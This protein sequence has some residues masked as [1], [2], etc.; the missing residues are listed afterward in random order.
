MRGSIKLDARKWNAAMKELAGLAK[1]KPVVDVMKR[2]AGAVVRRVVNVTPPAQGKADASAKKAGEGTIFTDLSRVM[3][4]V[5]QTK[6]AKLLDPVEVYKQTHNP[7]T[8]RV[9]GRYRKQRPVPAQAFNALKRQL[10]GKVGH[11][12]AGFNAAAQKLGVRL[13]A[14][15]TRHGLRFGTIGIF[16]KATGVRITFSN[17]VKFVDNVSDLGR[18]L[19]WALNTEAKS[20]IERQLPNAVRNVGKSA[21]FKT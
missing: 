21:G 18:R 20:I 16:L 11:L 3:L 4:P 6:G 15:I 1:K 14:W 9:N 17:R 5:K 2:G 19:Q 12:A 13:P 7:R 8:G 10:F